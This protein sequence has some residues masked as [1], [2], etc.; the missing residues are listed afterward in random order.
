MAKWSR[1]Q[2]CVWHPVVPALG[3]CWV[4][5]GAFRDGWTA[6]SIAGVSV[7]AIWFAGALY[8]TLTR[9]KLLEWFASDD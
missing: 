1:L 2:A 4:V 9:G 7:N 3:L 5:H 6:F 8:N